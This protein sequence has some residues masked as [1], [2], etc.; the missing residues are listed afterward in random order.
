MTVVVY[1]CDICNRKITLPQNPQ[2]LETV[3]RCTITLGCRGRLHQI[4]L[5]PDYIRGVFP[6]PVSGLKDWVQRKVL[7]THTQT[8]KSRTW[9]ITHNLGIIPTIQVFVLNPQGNQIEIFPSQTTVIDLNTVILEFSQLEAGI[10]QFTTASSENITNPETP[11]QTTITQ[12]QLSN[13]SNLT[14][15]NLEA[16]LFNS[17]KGFVAINPAVQGNIISAGYQIIN[18]GGT[19]T[20]SS[21]TGLSNDSTIYTATV[22]VD[23]V[24][25]AL[26]INVTGSSAQNY[27]QL[28]SVINSFLGLQATATLFSGNIKIT[29]ATIGNSSSILALNAE[30]S[31]IDL[32]LTFKAQPDQSFTYQDVLVSVVSPW[33]NY[34]TVLIKNKTYKVRNISILTNPLILNGTIRNSTPVVFSSLNS[35]PITPGSVLIL[36]A[37]S[38][39]QTVDKITNSFLDVTNINPSIPQMYYSNGD[40]FVPNNLID[41]TFPDIKKI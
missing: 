2:G 11:I 28:L 5:K 26:N 23:G 3:G 33:V 35:S 6:P 24:N 21:P 36:L 16:Y 20:L 18:V 10:A 13:S 17:L 22:T 25:P 34:P 7:Y 30:T 40:F 8:V 39:Y 12:L 1:Q 38:P 15:A 14:I 41:T 19:K 31:E 9:T 37:N 4:D 29:S 32:N 27:S